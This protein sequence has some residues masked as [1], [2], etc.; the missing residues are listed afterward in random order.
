MH[1]L[2]Q[3]AL[4]DPFLADAIEG[5][6]QHPDPRQDLSD[7]QDRLNKKVAEDNR[8]LTIMR[9]RRRVTLAAALILLLGIGYTFFYRHP[10][11]R[12]DSRAVSRTVSRADSR[13]DS[14]TDSPADLA[15]KILE[16]SPEPATVAAGT[17]PVQPATVAANKADSTRIAFTQPNIN[18]S[19]GTHQ[20]HLPPA[21]ASSAPPVEYKSQPT[22]APDSNN[23]DKII[24]DSLT[25]QFS[26][27][28][29]VAKFLDY[30]PATPRIYSGK[31]LDLQNRPL[32]GAFLALSGNPATGTTTDDQGQFK[33]SLHPRDTARQLTISLIGYDH[34][35]LAVNNL[36]F[37]DQASNVIHL[38]PSNANLDEVVVVGYG[39]HRKATEAA[40]PST[41]S[42]RLDSLWHSAAPVIG[43]QAYL[44]YLKIEKNKLGL[45]T[46]ITGPETVSFIVSPDGSLSSFK[47][48]QSLSPAHDNAIVHLVTDGPAWR[49]IR[50]KKVRAAVTVNF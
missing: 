23:L 17:P 9:I 33:I 35:S 13:A 39:M 28:T 42:E 12:A 45:D 7:L 32:A 20:H 47:I 38:A 10:V 11:S 26:N 43:R 24:N 50:G 27:K 29:T 25:I 1:D 19:L 5:L 18:H 8:R 16:P 6:I 36:N 4:D 2:E 49:L 15:S 22:Q 48:E 14:R 3:A 34:T 41:S 30:F 37:Q 44:Q 46:T 31:V 40:A 21:V